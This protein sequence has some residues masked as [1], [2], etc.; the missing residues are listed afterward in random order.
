MTILD[1]ILSD[2]EIENKVKE[3]EVSNFLNT[4][5]DDLRAK[6]FDRE[7]KKQSMIQIL[8]KWLV[9]RV[10]TPY[11]PEN[12]HIEYATDTVKGQKIWRI[13]TGGTGGTGGQ[14]N[15]YAREKIGGKNTD[16]Q[17][18]NSHGEQSNL[19]PVPPV[20]PVVSGGENENARAFYEAFIS[21]PDHSLR[22]REDGTIGIG[23]PEEM[24]DEEFAV[25]DAQV[26]TMKDALLEVL[27]QQAK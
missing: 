27:R 11:G 25:I 14:N 16:T 22:I 1:H 13:N 20:P 8:A 26:E 24:S 21:K 6:L 19:P 2:V 3:G 7:R 4:L 5:P 12:L 17:P 18:I 23:V 10:K 15:R 9:E